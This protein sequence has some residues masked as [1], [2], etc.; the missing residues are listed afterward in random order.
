MI[1]VLLKVCCGVFAVVEHEMRLATQ[2]GWEQPVLSEFYL[3]RC[4]QKFDFFALQGYRCRIT[5]S[6]FL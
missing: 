4:L 5:G 1:D 2:I 6:Q 3:A